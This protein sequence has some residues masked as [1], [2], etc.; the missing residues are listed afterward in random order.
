MSVSAPHQSLGEVPRQLT[1]FEAQSRG[2]SAG[3]LRFAPPVTRTGRKT[4]FRLLA[5]LCREGLDS[6]RVRT[7]GFTMRRA[8]I[9]L[10]QALPGASPENVPSVRN[11]G[12]RLCIAP[13]DKLRRA[14]SASL[15]HPF[16][17]AHASESQPLAANV[18][19]FELFSLPHPMTQ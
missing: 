14:G 16:A 8:S 12:P 11:F 6:L 7:K 1:T 17:P 2:F 13:L 9:P 3:C 18:M 10:P 19:S 4:R 5:K 15:P